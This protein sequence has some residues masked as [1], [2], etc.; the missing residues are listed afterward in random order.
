MESVEERKQL[1]HDDPDILIVEPHRVFCR[2]CDKW[3]KLDEVKL[4][5][6]SV[7]RCHK[8]TK[9]HS[10]RASIGTVQSASQ[11][12][13]PNHN[14]TNTSSQSDALL[15]ESA[16]ILAQEVLQNLVK[17]PSLAR[18]VSQT[19]EPSRLRSSGFVHIS[20]SPAIKLNFK[21]SSTKPEKHSRVQKTL[22]DSVELRQPTN[23]AAV[24]VSEAMRRNS[25]AAI[26]L[27]L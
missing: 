27:D 17:A 21:G 7:W 10:A 20:T 15:S 24:T 13:D 2:R 6:A 25:S 12:P 16:A 14:S 8:N 22:K 23:I 4:Y 5:A 19:G 18:R 11:T 3:L 9:S 1:L 26:G